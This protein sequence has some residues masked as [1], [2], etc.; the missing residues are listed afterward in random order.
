MNWLGAVTL[1]VAIGLFLKWSFDMGWITPLFHLPPVAYLCL[2]WLAGAGL[3]GGAEIL[4]GRMPFY[5]QGLAGGGSATL[6][7]TTY[8]G[9][10]LISPPTPATRC[11][12]RSRLRWRCWGWRSP[13]P[14]L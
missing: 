13:A 2:G 6:Y 7:L 12:T 14:S 1:V 9:Y 8:A 11:S 10:A 5:A 4:R 3:L